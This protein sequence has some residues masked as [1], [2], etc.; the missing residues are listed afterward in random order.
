MN[1]KLFFIF[2]FSFLLIGNISA[3]WVIP[4][5]T[6]CNMLNV[7]GSSCDSVWCSVIDCTYNSTLEAC[8]CEKI[9]DTFNSSIYYNKSQI[10]SIIE[11]KIEDE[12]EIYN[13]SILSKQIDISFVNQSYVNEKFLD[14]KSDIDNLKRDTIYLNPKN[15]E[16]FN[17][18]WILIIL[19]VVGGGL[20]FI[21][22]FI[23]NLNQEITPIQRG[24]AQSSYRKIQSKNDM[25]KDEEIEKLKRNLKEKQNK[26]IEEKGESIEEDEENIDK[27][28]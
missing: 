16:E 21:F 24:V 25:S 6:T 3:S 8:I 12:L 5:S 9:I 15:S 19:I 23:P 18:I 7:T 28:E 1:K 26:K 10:E 4:K 17:P 22:K 27:Y 13:E 20:F 11:E 2:L 14:L